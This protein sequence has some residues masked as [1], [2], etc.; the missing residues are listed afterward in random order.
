MLGGRIVAQS[1]Q[2]MPRSCCG[3]RSFID[4]HFVTPHDRLFSLYKLET[5]VCDAL[6]QLNFPWL[7]TLQ[8]GK[9]L[10]SQLG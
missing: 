9:S 10:P 2:P 7:T 8:H 4:P 1:L 3:T 5:V 6:R